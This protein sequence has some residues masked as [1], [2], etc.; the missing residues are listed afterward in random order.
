VNIDPRDD[1]KWVA[2]LQRLERQEQRGRFP[3]QEVDPLY[4]RR[5]ANLARRYFQG[6]FEPYD[7]SLGSEAKDD[8]E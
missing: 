7:Y 8:A 6:D 5:Q 1:K 4:A 2:R 3:K